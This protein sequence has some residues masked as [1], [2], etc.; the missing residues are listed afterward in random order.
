MVQIHCFSLVQVMQLTGLGLNLCLCSG[1]P[2]LISR[3]KYSTNIIAD[4]DLLYEATASVYRLP[5]KPE[6][7]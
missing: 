3:A 7:L 6:P 5:T 2:T 4:I 1:L